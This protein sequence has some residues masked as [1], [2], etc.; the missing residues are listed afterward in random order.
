MITNNS[1]GAALGMY[2]GGGAGTM[3]EA[4]S[5]RLSQKTL[6]RLPGAPRIPESVPKF[7]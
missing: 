7:L 3:K 2:G 1:W 4:S 6:G 5:G